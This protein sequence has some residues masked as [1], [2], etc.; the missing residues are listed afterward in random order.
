[1]HLNTDDDLFYVYNYSLW[2]DIQILIRTPF[3][4][5]IGRGAF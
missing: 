4:V 3:A 2:L 1:M 5:L